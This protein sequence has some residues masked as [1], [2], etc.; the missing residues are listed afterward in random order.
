MTYGNYPDLTGVKKILVIKLRH[1]GDV[2]LTSP[3]FSYLKKSLPDVRIDVLLYK[4]TLP[5]LEGHP[6]IS[7]FLL[8]DKK[9][10]Q[11][12]FLGKLCKEIAL[13][14][15]IRR[16]QYDCI[17]N[18]TE[19]DR[20]AIAARLS[21][22]RIRVGF[23]PEGKGMRGKRSCYTHIVKIVPTPRHTVSPTSAI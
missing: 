7:A 9:W 1:H 8:Y 19:G 10:K 6:D 17:I 21:G 11:L 16:H 2:L 15:T 14:R 20:G 3:L 12:S 4:E 18:L 5:M 23:D 22:S 13:F